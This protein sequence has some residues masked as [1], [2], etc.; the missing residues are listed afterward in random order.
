MSEIER[1]RLDAGELLLWQLNL[2]A[3]PEILN[4]LSDVV[5]AD[6]RERAARFHFE[7]DR[8]RFLVGRGALRCILGRYLA[9]QPADIS[10]VYGLRGKPA[11]AGIPL[12]FNMSHSDGMAV[13]AVTRS[14]VV[15]IDLE[16]VRPMPDLEGIAK[17][18][19]S[20]TEQAAIATLPADDRLSAFFTCWTRKEAYLKATGDGIAAGLSS[21]DVTVIPG[22]YPRLLRVDGKPEETERWSFYD[23]PLAPG[24]VGVVVVEGKTLGGGPSD[25]P[26]LDPK[27]FSPLSDVLALWSLAPGTGIQLKH[28]AST[29]LLL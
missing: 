14:H 12:H 11:I 25:P 3:S 26:P 21:F 6:E 10:F 18:H 8:S 27:M 20:S 1:E 16:H 22:T 15:G 28:M 2:D 17:S 29:S 23:L 7:Q 9:E 19:F 5:S 4:A 24:F 13:I